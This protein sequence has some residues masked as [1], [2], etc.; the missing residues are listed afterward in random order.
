MSLDL[1]I[2][3]L[4]IFKIFFLVS[5]NFNGIFDKSFYISTK[6][7]SSPIHLMFCQGITISLFCENIFNTLLLPG[8]IIDVMVTRL[9]VGLFCR[10]FIVINVTQKILFIVYHI[11]LF[12]LLA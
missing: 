4:K 9:I 10:M 3:S 1:V 5:L 7:K 12:F 11:F 2:F 8:T 6:I